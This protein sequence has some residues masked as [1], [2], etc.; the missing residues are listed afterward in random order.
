M[1]T[2]EAI[3]CRY[4]TCFD[5]A[6][7]YPE[8]LAPLAGLPPDVQHDAGAPGA[9]SK[10]IPHIP[11]A[12]VGLEYSA[13]T[14]MKKDALIRFWIGNHDEYDRLIRVRLA[15]YDRWRT[16]ERALPNLLI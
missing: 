12:R 1:R 7:N 9:F 14:I 3:R 2:A 8:V 16:D 15:G 11:S 5:A 6:P 13:L 10:T 4:L